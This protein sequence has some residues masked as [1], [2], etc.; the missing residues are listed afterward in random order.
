MKKSMAQW[1]LLLLLLAALNI[2]FFFPSR[3]YETSNPFTISS[4]ALS[5]EA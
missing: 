5:R 4:L 1:E 3:E 2:L